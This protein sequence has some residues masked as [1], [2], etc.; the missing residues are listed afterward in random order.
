MIMLMIEEK[1]K[2]KGAKVVGIVSA[3]VVL[4]LFGIV[5][6]WLTST[7]GQAVPGSTVGDDQNFA[8][9]VIL[10]GISGL[11]ILAIILLACWRV[12][13]KAFFF[14]F[15]IGLW[16]GLGLYALIL[17][18]GIVS[19]NVPATNVAQQCTTSIDKYRQ[20]GSAIVPIATDKGQGTGFIIDNKGTILTANHVVQDTTEQYASYSSGRINLKVIDQAPEY[21]LALLRLEKYEEVHFPLSDTYDVGDSV[22][23]Y[24]YPGNAYSA[25]APSITSGIISRLLSTEDLRMTN[26]ATPTGFNLIQT[27]AA[28]NPGNSGGPLIGACGVIGII[29]A[30][31]DSAE[32]SDYVGAVSEQGIGYAVSIK[33]AANRFKLPLLPRQ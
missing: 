9:T 22:Y 11:L 32:L 25:G 1:K 3:W 24:G 10:N 16:I 21:D 13:K 31:S 17:I 5:M 14:H 28:I 20:F 27:D 12:R 23:A 6:L 33:T 30:V 18:S 29:I 8:G 15:I 4:P 26:S 19:Y 7:I 2:N